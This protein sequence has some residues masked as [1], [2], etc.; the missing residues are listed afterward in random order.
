MEI[1]QAKE[2]VVLAGTELVRTGLIARTW[3]NVS[4]RTGG[5]SFAV[6]PSGRAYETLTPKEIVLCRTA[7]ASYEG[8]IKPSS[9]RGVHALVYRMRPEVGFVIHTHQLWASAVSACGLGFIPAEGFP[10]LGDRVPVAAYGLPGTKKLR[11]G[12]AQAL[13]ET[14][15]SAV[16]MAHHG[17]LC[18]GRDYGEA[19]LAAHQLEQAC[20]A[21][22]RKVFE[23]KSGRAFTGVS[24]L[25]AYD[26]S[27]TR[28][29]PPSPI[30]PASSRRAPGGFAFTNRDTQLPQDAG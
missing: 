21:Y 20:E 24:S 23:Q 30:P 29:K 3:G 25:A 19:F 11:A 4:C 28:A 22:V 9:E 5:S 1:Q 8:E 10:L 6:T 14:G 15:G 16:I 2:Q 18:F 27:Q 26:L 7:D 12:V 13:L 17:A